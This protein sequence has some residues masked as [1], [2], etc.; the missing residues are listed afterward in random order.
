MKQG[1]KKV[2]KLYWLAG[3]FFIICCINAQSLFLS[4]VKNDTPD[5]IYKIII[6]DEDYEILVPPATE[7]SFGSWLDLQREK[8][9]QLAV[10]TGEGDPIFVTKGPESAGCPE[11][12]ISQSIVYWSGFPSLDD[13]QKNYKTCCMQKGDVTLALTIAPDGTPQIEDITPP[14]K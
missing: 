11:E 3:T 4:R 9:V 7:A 14:N 2:S 12:A 5:T 10:I 1:E 6:P 8:E 13:S